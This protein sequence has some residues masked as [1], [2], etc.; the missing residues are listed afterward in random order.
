[1]TLCAG[2]FHQAR[3]QHVQYIGKARSKADV[4]SG[5]GKRP[6]HSERRGGPLFGVARQGVAAG[7]RADELGALGD[8]E[9][10]SGASIW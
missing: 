1:M 5:D 9:H 8:D 4:H 3:L 10:V 6:G 7:Q 2:P